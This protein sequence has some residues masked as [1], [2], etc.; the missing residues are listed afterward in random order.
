MTLAK[1]LDPSDPSF[2]VAFYTYVACVLPF[3]LPGFTRMNRSLWWD[4]DIWL[5]RVFAVAGAVAMA[6]MCACFAALIMGGEF[7]R[8]RGLAPEAFQ[9]GVWAG[10]ITN[11]VIVSYEIMRQFGDKPHDETT[12]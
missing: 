7:Q 6:V 10:W 3:A 5:E 9:L 4:A 2:L 12:A 1:F 11:A 8:L